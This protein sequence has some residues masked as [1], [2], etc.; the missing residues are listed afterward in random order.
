MAA[1]AVLCIA[2]G[3]DSQTTESLGG[4]RGPSLTKQDNDYFRDITESNLTEIQSSQM[5]L[6][7]SSSPQVKEFAQKM[8][9]DHQTA[10]TQVAAV[11]K[12][13]DV[14]PPTML[15]GSH[16]D[17]AASLNGKSGADFDKAY[18][19]L[20]VKSHEATINIDQDEADNGNDGDVKNLANTLLPTLQQHLMM[21]KKLQSGNM[22]GM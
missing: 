2:V 12:T 22:S 20:Q 15:D 1:A 6:Q 13:K 8:I 7:M 19:D 17:M 16:K 21:A 4:S 9:N 3:C 11:A 10:G 14:T 5:A 18:V